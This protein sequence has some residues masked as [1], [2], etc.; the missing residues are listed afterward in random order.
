MFLPPTEQVLYATGA[1]LRTA[2]VP[3]TSALSPNQAVPSGTSGLLS[4]RPSDPNLCGGRYH[5]H[6][7]VYIN[8]RL[9]WRYTCQ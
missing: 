4:R 3:S 9:M 6:T 8:G 1:P 7:A 2:T 5:T